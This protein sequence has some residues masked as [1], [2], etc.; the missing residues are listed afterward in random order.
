MKALDRGELGEDPD[1]KYW[2]FGALE[3]FSA[4]ALET[5]FAGSETCMKALDRGELGED[6]WM[7]KCLDI[8]Q[9]D[10]IK[11]TGLL[12]DGYCNEAPSPCVSGKVA[13]HP[14]KN[15]EAYFACRNEAQSADKNKKFKK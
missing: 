4:K 1:H 7:R 5:Y 8:L 6:T 9:V 2:F 3:V 10:S 12:S 13:F 15:A 11:D 14:F